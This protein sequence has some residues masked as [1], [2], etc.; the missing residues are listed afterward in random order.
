MPDLELADDLKKTVC[1]RAGGT[2][3]LF[4]SITGR[5]TPVV[6]WRKT[7]VEL[8]SRGYI[9][10]TDSYTSLTVEKVDRYDSGKYIVEAENPSGKKTVTI[11]VK[12][13]GM[14]CFSTDT[15]YV[16]LGSCVKKG[17]CIE[18]KSFKY[19]C[20]TIISSCTCFSPADTP[21]PPGLV[22][23]KDYTKESVVI[24]WDV[25]SVD[26]GAH[27]SNYIIEKREAN[28][29]SYKT[30]T[31][32][33]RKTLFRITGLDEGMH[34]FFRV[35]PENIYGVG[36]PCET[37]EAVL[38]CDVPSVPLNLQVVDVSR[39]SATLQWEKP[40][41]DGGSRLTGYI[42]EACKVGSD[43]WSAVATLKATVSHHTIQSLMERDQY[44]FRIRATN[45]RGSSEPMDIVTPV[46]IQEIKGKLSH[47][48]FCHH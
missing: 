27:V 30:V 23:V 41:H 45:S 26:G 20:I 16:S 31:T 17:C 13:Y 34:Y 21:G 18:S 48:H 42:I 40:L 33:C 11:L 4:V 38:V 7:G 47:N 25:P 12:V 43:R 46:T 8:Q 1:L 44:L 28:M 3:R 32:E 15:K 39:S 9:E 29:K 6:A 35:L 19:I 22:R 14:S 2:L 37:A 10:T 5:P 36:E 24:T